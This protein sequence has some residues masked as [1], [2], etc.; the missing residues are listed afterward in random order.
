MDEKLIVS[1]NHFIFF[2]SSVKVSDDSRLGLVYRQI[3]TSDR[4]SAEK[5]VPFGKRHNSHI[6]SYLIWTLNLRGSFGQR[7]CVPYPLHSSI[8]R[9]EIV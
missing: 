7:Q 1:I 8:V 4:Y 9:A 6:V 3:F 2:S 5:S